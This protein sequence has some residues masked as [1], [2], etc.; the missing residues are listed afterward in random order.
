[1]VENASA[2]SKRYGDNLPVAGAWSGGLSNNAEQITVT[3]NGTI[4]QQFR[5]DDDWYPETDGAGS[6]LQIIDVENT[7][8]S[9]WNNSIKDSLL[10]LW[11]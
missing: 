2:F 8:L 4:L 5:Y 7:E 11:I 10:I 6:S 1:M 9:D 3:H